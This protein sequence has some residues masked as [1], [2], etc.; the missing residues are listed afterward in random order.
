MRPQTK[1]FVVLGRGAAAVL[2]RPSAR[3]TRRRSR[4]SVVVPPAD[5]MRPRA[6]RL[7]HARRRRASPLYFAGPM[8]I[9]EWVL[10]AVE[11]VE[12]DVDH[13][14]AR[15]S[16]RVS[17]RGAHRLADDR[18][19]TRPSAPRARICLLRA[20]AVAAARVASSRSAQPRS[21]SSGHWRSALA[22]RPP[23]AAT[24]PSGACLA[25]FEPPKRSR[26]QS[27]AVGAGYDASARVTH[28]SVKYSR[29]SGRPFNAVSLFAVRLVFVTSAYPT[30]CTA[31]P[32]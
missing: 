25:N 10:V 6:V 24:D 20:D 12:R 11:P 28:P 21:C 23:A 5:S 32:R 27:E 7:A 22:P 4:P 2:V 9:A 29:P 14:S 18:R 1:C 26:R 30:P 31:R 3:P 19:K 15:S 16:A 8:A 13:R 17:T